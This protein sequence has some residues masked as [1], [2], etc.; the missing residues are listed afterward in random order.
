LRPWGWNAT[1]CR[2]LHQAGATAD[3]L[4]TRE[5]LSRWR[6]VAHRR[7]TIAMHRRM[8]ALLGKPLCP[9]P[10]ELSDLDAVRQFIGRC[11]GGAYL[12][13]PW[14][15][16]GRGICHVLDADADH[17]AMRWAEGAI[18]HQGS[19]LCEQGLERVQDCAVE[20]QCHAGRC[21]VTGLS[22]FDSDFH[23]QYGGGVIDSQK[24]LHTLLA[25]QCAELDT[26][27]AALSEALEAEV[28]P[29]YDGVLGVDMMV[30]RD[31]HKQLSLNPCVEINLRHTMGMVAAS[32]GEVH[33]L[34]GTF[35]VGRLPLPTD[36]VA[37]TP[38]EAA[39]RY[40]AFFV[41]LK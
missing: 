32:L 12:K 33:G 36:A 5:E 11:P 20:F 29:V 7:T 31:T 14:S 10:V 23:S 39:S 27:V 9:T 26:V 38:V 2:L 8:T 17:H 34:R 21:T 19:L 18:R 3:V 35:N 13:M 30:Y 37:L 25:S 4:P 16:S 40:A 28:A 24:R 41:P 15:G 1:L 22:V 6:A